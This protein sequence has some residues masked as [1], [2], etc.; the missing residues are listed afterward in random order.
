M[1][2]M[3]EVAFKKM[4]HF[5]CLVLIFSNSIYICTVVLHIMLYFHLR[6][7]I[8]LCVYLNMLILYLTACRKDPIRAIAHIRPL[9]QSY[10]CST[11][12]M[13]AYQVICSVVVLNVH[14][15]YHTCGC[16]V[17]LHLASSFL[18]KQHCEK[19]RLLVW[20]LPSITFLNVYI[21]CTSP[22]LFIN[23]LSQNSEKFQSIILTIQQISEIQFTTFHMVRMD[24]L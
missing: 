17:I 21:R 11:H 12:N 15:V 4:Y 5:I 13:A 2:G 18:T 14:M 3:N 7:F 6:V 16:V 20:I 10:T 22:S 1:K 9:S 23:S 24:V 19:Q 8:F